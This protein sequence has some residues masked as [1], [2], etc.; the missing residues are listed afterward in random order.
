M[1]Q[2]T[3]E[4]EIVVKTREMKF[5]LERILFEFQEEKVQAKF[6]EDFPGFTFGGISIKPIASGGQE[7]I[8]YF[9]A[10]Y[11]YE[12]GIIEDFRQNFPTK[13]QDVANSL[14]S[15]L[16]TG[17]LQKVDQFFHIM[18]RDIIMEK[19]GKES[20]FTELELKRI[21]SSFQKLTAERVSK[22]IKMTE[23][24]DINIRKSN[25]TNSERILFRQILLLLKAWKNEF[26]KT[27]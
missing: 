5:E 16:R 21:K 22:L 24:K 4:Q 3:E 20:Q 18:M 8:P 2:K 19:E 15:E 25:F 26:L 7:L 12:K 1:K 17:E 10:D 13:L 27:T 6:K 23:R 11:L 9:I 14:R